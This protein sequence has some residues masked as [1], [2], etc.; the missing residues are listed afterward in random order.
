[1]GAGAQ[2]GSMGEWGAVQDLSQVSLLTWVMDYGLGSAGG[3]GGV[4]YES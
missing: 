4:K 2:S 3:E 1:M